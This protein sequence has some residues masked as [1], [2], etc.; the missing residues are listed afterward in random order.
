MS[1]N[2]FIDLVDSFFAYVMTV[3]G[4]VISNYIPELGKNSVINVKL[5]TV[6]LLLSAVVALM[7]VGQQETKGD[8]IGKRKNFIPRMANALAHG[9]A[10]NSLIQIAGGK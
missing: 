9:I 2:R 6:R 10:W 3:L 1:L 5:D 8:P 7:I 4:V